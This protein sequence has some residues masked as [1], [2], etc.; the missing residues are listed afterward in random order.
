M[1]IQAS[2]SWPSASHRHAQLQTRSGQRGAEERSGKKKNENQ[3]NWMR[4]KVAK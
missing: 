1:G 4:V 3:S 2:S